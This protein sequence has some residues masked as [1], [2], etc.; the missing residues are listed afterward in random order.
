MSLHPLQEAFQAQTCQQRINFIRDIHVQEFEQARQSR[1][2]QSFVFE[3][4]N[5]AYAVLEAFWHHD[6]KQMHIDD[7]AMKE[8]M[9]PLWDQ[10]TDRLSKYVQPCC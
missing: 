10:T 2:D 8:I 4:D 7:S 3:D 6:Y 1:S 9:L 5:K